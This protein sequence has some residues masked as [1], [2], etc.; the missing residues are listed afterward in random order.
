MPKKGLL[1]VYTGNG[2]GKTTAALGLSLRAMGH[3]LNVCLIQFIKG[4]RQ[5]GELAALQRFSDCMVFHVTGYGFT[6]KSEDIEKDRTAAREGW[7]LAKQAIASEKY[8]MLILDELTYLVKLNMLDEKEILR[9]L[10]SRPRDLHVIVTGRD[11]SPALK[12]SAD[13]VTE[14][15][16][17]KHPLEK[18]VK[19]QK[20]IEF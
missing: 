19:A 8:Q 7:R 5:T 9:T 14:M 11:A 6:W 10:R 13:L 15:Q 3:G 12:E 2:K 18:G 16:A 1:L 17:V 4:S 20:G